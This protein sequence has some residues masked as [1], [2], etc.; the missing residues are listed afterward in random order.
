MVKHPD[1]VIGAI[2]SPLYGAWQYLERVTSQQKAV[3]LSQ[4]KLS[5]AR[6]VQ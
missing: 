5:S 3:L 6:A 4:Q 2:A 1:L